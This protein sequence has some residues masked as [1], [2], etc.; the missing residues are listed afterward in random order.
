MSHELERLRE[1]HR[2]IEPPDPEVLDGVRR[3][4]LAAAERE[5]GRRPRLL[6]PAGRRRRPVRRLAIAGAAAAAIA[7]AVVVLPSD[8]VGGPRVVDA[9]AKARQALAAPGEIVHY[10]LKVDGPS[11]PGCEVG[12]M[13]IW[14]T[15][16]PTRWHAV[17]P[18]P[19]AERCGS[20]D[21]QMGE[22][23]VPPRVEL[24]YHG[25]RLQTYVPGS[26]ILQVIDDTD[27]PREGERRAPSD[28]SN[29]A[30]LQIMGVVAKARRGFE[31]AP[32]IAR[33]PDP[34][35]G[36]EQ[37]LEDGE[38]RDTG[39]RDRGG[40]LVR[41]LAG[42]SHRLDIERT[43]IKYVVDADTFAPIAVSATTRVRG[44][45]TGTIRAT[46]GDYERIPLTADTEKLLEIQPER[47][48]Q[49]TRLTIEQIKGGGR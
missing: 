3:Q 16:Q 42:T 38:L 31:E 35:T 44:G 17:Q 33:L 21:L 43:E 46:F 12:P 7:A 2:R 15:A 28:A 18:V 27:Q 6:T 22:P 10:T 34:V 49:V 9:I 47:R 8:E 45:A 19:D 1:A 11:A 14:R 37:L 30:T 25:G 20:A 41:V 26:D 39:V 5:S 24:A 40:G 4:L 23:I 32:A 13:E 29:M 36:V 48:P